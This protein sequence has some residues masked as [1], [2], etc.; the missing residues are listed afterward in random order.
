MARPRTVAYKVYKFLREAKV[1]SIH[2]ISVNL[3]I[4]PKNV[5]SAIQTLVRSGHVERVSDGVYRV[6]KLVW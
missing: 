1:A 2:D 6:K 3:G 4:N 5:Y